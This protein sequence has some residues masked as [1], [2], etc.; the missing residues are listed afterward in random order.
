MRKRRK[1]DEQRE[2]EQYLNVAEC[3]EN[4]EQKI[5]TGKRRGEQ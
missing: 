2:K 1:G 5:I 4:K 3:R